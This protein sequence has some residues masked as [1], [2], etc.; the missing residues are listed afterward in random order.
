MSSSQQVADLVLEGGGVKGIAL[1]GAVEV[2]EEYGY[3]FKRVAGTSAGAIVGAL[4]AA[5]VP[6][7]ELVKIM[8]SLHYP[9]FRDGSWYTRSLP[10]KAFAVA[11]R[12]GVYRGDHLKTWLQEHLDAYGTRTFADI[13]YQDPDRPL[14]PHEAF[15]LVVT[16][17]DLSHGRLSYLPRDYARNGQEAAAHQVVDAVRASMSIPFFYRPAHSWTSDRRRIWLVDGGML[18]NFPITVFDAPRGTRPRWPTFGIKLSSRRDALLHK[19]SP[20]TGPLSLGRAMLK[21]LTGFYD[22]MHIDNPDAQARTIFVDTGSVRATDFDITAAQRDA[23]YRAGR[24]AAQKFLDGTSHR[25][26]WNFEEYIRTHRTPQ[27]GQ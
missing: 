17:S 19:P 13:H 20:I 23:L 5:G 22:R 9:D 3:H 21:T 18:S 14:P 27:N 16:A 7:P 11:T 6:A 15:R 12:L 4:I 1:V 26:A 8:A 24:N 25:P 10:G 2:L